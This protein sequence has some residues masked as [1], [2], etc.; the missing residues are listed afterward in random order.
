M[1]IKNC[2]LVSSGKDIFRNILV[3]NGKIAS[4][5]S[6]N[7]KADKEIDAKKNYV[8]PGIIDPHV[9]FREP[10]MTHKEDF[11]TGSV[12]AAAGGITTILDMPNTNPP[13][14]TAELLK[15]KK[16]LARKSIVNYGL[17]FGAAIDNIKE[18]IKVRDKV[19]STKLF[20]NLSTGKMMIDDRIKLEQIFEVSKIVAVHAEKEKVAEAVAYSKKTGTP[21]YLCHISL[22]DEID[23]LR[24]AKNRKIF[25]E[26]TPHH[27]FLTE[28]DFRKQ[29]GFADMKPNL[30]SKKDQD[31]L[32]KAID[33]G[34]I[35]TIGTDHAPHTKEEKR[36]KEHP[37]GVPGCETAL[38][39]MLDAV[40]RGKISLTRVVRLMCVNPAKIFRIKNKGRL[41]EGYDAD[42]TILDMNKK[43]KVQNKELFTKCKWSPFDGKILKGWPVITIVGGNVV[44][45]ETGF[46]DIKA[47]EV[48]FDG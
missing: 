43:K 27:L 29:K 30:K 5:T 18:I 41:K 26:A 34:I 24:K 31:A 37:S 1:L 9:H 15:E 10:G 47:K 35:D 39:L 8:I 38:P 20:M 19:A 17:H 23:F 11:F 40:N 25:A 42:L 32:W 13:T 46:Y 33:E 7:L 36:K 6:K 16:H 44:F 14:T 48:V 3:K 2:R 12:A 4:I 45:D 22:K 28:S 21:L